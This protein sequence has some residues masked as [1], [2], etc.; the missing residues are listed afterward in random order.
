MNIRPLWGAFL[1]LCYPDESLKI[2]T[3]PGFRPLWGAF[4]FLCGGIRRGSFQR[5]V[6]VPYGDLFYFYAL[7]E[8]YN[9]F[10]A[11]SPSPMGSFFISIIGI[12]FD[13]ALNAILVSVPYGDLFDFYK[14]KWCLDKYLELF[15]S[16]MGIFFIFMEQMT[17]T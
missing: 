3:K 13:K 4:L 5:H 15:P 17:C 10:E 8:P 11:E 2:K 6:S 12:S 7:L 1:F 16:P 14:A 9:K